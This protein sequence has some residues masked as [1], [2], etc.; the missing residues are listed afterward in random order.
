MSKPLTNLTIAKPATHI[1]FNPA[2][3]VEIW[4]LTRNSKKL[5]S[6]L[7]FAP[8]KPNYISTTSLPANHPQ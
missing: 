5:L 4:Q 6:R 1:N 3:R 8:S 7:I 2:F